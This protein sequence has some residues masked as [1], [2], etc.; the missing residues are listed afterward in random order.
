[1]PLVPVTP[2]AHEAELVARA[3]ALSGCTLAQ[4]AERFS[5]VAPPDLRRAKGFVGA[6]VERALGA[7]AG[8][9]AAPDFEALG[10]EL[11]TL[12]VDARGR[13]LE[14]TFVCTIPLTEIGQ[15]E[16]ASS[17][18]RR[19]LSR[20]LWVPVEGERGIPVAERHIGEPLLWSLSPVIEAH[21]RFDWEELAGIIGRGD[22]ETITG[23]I[24]RCLQIRPKARDSRARRRGVDVDGVRFAALP[25]GFYLRASFTSE[26]LRQNY[27]L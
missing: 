13:A 12:P 14:S 1:M 25:R 16:W 8:S 27:A 22:V 23:H 2:P 5:L 10:I 15:V 19:K 17:R 9:R 20:V 26:I 21:L 4:I 7:S 6:L 11:K 24:G 18:V 3:R